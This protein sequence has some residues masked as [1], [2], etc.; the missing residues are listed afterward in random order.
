MAANVLRSERATLVSI[1]IV[2]AFTRF[3]HVLTIHKEFVKEVD[4]LKSFALKHFNTTDREFRRVWRAIERLS[5]PGSD[6]QRRIGFS[7]D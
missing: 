4:E 1:E 7:L 2:R 6:P 3:R 5:S